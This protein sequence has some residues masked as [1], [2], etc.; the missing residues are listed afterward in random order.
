MNIR[1]QKIKELINETGEARLSELE[2][3]F[4]D[5]SAMTI[6]RDLD[7]LESMGEVVR[8]RS[9]AKSIAHLSRLNE[10]LYSERA[11]EHIAE[12]SE[13]AK[14]AHGLIEQGSTV[15]MDAGTTVTELAKM[16][17]N[18]KLFVITTAPNIALECIKRPD[19]SVFMTGGRLSSGN[20]SL[21][22]INAVG[23]LDQINIDIAFMAASGAT[24]KNGFTSGNYDES[25]I[26]KRVIEKAAKVV[27][28]ADSS[29]YAKS[30]PFTF[31]SLSDI[32]TLITDDKMDQGFTDELRKHGVEV[33]I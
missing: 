2:E 29:K 22:G 30:L 4:P 28:L 10:P 26:K 23:F 19:V 11:R 6:R 17:A 25:Q 24:L 16:L 14:K 8:T 3:M 31:A 18:D 20:L 15:F 27:M 33:M 5:Y 1:Q 7:K 12:K 21:S 9:G 13:I 32:N